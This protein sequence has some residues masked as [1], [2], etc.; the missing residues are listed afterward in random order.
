MND[1]RIAL[2]FSSRCSR[3]NMVRALNDFDAALRGWELVDRARQLPREARAML[4]VDS[5]G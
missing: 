2:T 3:V 1:Q 5:L 4:G